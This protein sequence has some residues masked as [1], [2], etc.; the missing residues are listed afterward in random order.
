MTLPFDLGF[1]AAAFMA[2]AI[3]L[4]AFVRGYSGF[5][6]SA[7][8]ISAA[9]LVTNPLHA[10]AVV[11]L[12]E[13]LM[14]VQAWRGI[15]AYI[16]WRRVWLLMAGA[17]IGM[18]LGLW[19]LTSISEDAAR[20][21]ISGY[22][23]IMCLVLLAGWKLGR[24]VRGQGNFWAGLASGLANA[25]GMGGLPVVA[26]FAAQTMPAHVFRATLVAYFPLLDIYAAPLYFYSGLVS[27]DTLWASLMA[28]PMVFLGNWLGS[29]HFLNTDPQDFRKFAIGLLALL[30]VLGLLKSVL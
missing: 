6:F 18:P 12:C 7:L 11:V 19:A 30:S 13:A 29:R 27:W 25:P 16:D 24:E 21:V 26:F 20:A 2:V 10:V 17:A 14:S 23:L 9:G 4:S 5:G 28:L 3:L 15:G 22:V 8:V 1:G